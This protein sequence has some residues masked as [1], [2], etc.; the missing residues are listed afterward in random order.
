MEEVWVVYLCLFLLVLVLILMKRDPDLEAA[1]KVKE[2]PSTPAPT[3]YYSSG[4]GKHL[5]YTEEEMEKSLERLTS[6]LYE[7][8]AR[9]RETHHE[10]KTAKA[11]A[12]HHHKAPDA[13]SENKELMGKG[14][15]HS[16]HLS[17]QHRVQEKATHPG[18]PGNIVD[19]I[20]LK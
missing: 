19:E 11:E 20:G 2:T 1:K 12:Y 15:G 10:Q 7:V 6:I 4:A 13:E 17:S 14:P 16:R 5:E 8:D 9:K 18:G 3:T